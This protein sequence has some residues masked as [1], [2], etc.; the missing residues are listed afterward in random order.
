MISED[1]LASDYCYDVEMQQALQRHKAQEAVLIPVILRPVL[2]MDAPFG[3]LQALPK[4][5][6]PIET[7][8]NRDEAYAN[9]AEGIRR[10]VEKLRSR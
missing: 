3:K 10:V 9:V 6:K 7:W 5:A 1:F 2:W 8:R 4:D